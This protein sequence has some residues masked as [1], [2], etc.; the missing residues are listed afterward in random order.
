[1]NTAPDLILATTNKGKLRELA[2]LLSGVRA[3]LRSLADFPDVGEAEE[4]GETFEENA[5]LKATFYGRLLG[6]TTL[7]DDS[8]L[9]VDALGGAPGVLSAR[10]AGAGAADALR[11]ERL[12]EELGRT[13]A[14]DRSARFVCV[15]A[16]YEPAAEGVRLFRGVCEGRI[17]EGPRGGN[18]FG[19]DPIFV[20]EGYEETFAQ[21]PSE[22]KQR[23]SHRARALA[24]AGAYLLQRFGGAANEEIGP[25]ESIR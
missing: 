19:Y 1:M 15:A 9:E 24:G 22:V 2:E 5:A 14:A 23:I 16:I 11:V 13:G 18:G 25:G 10:Y 3:R 7:T 17:A 4:T 8:G 12:L 20:P 6:A 21:L